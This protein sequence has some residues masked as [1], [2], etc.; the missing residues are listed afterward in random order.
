[1][2]YA[3]FCRS[4]VV[5]A[6]E[7]Q[8]VFLFTDFDS[9]KPWTNR[10]DIFQMSYSIVCASKVPLFYCYVTVHKLLGPCLFIKQKKKFTR[11][12][13][14]DAW[15]FRADLNCKVE[16]N[17]S[18]AKHFSKTFIRLFSV[19]R[20]KYRPGWTLNFDNLNSASSAISS[21]TQSEGKPWPSNTNCT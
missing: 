13:I 19:N 21:S 1:M 12:K 11:C 5:F 17:P 10:E 18:K 8:K 16:K 3:T 9:M 15:N 6:C 14:Y 20:P 4:T 2:C 7:S